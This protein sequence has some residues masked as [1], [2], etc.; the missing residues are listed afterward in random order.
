MSGTMHSLKTITVHV[1]LE[2]GKVANEASSN[3]DIL[4]RCLAGIYFLLRQWKRP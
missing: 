3:L 2:S 4:R 1:I